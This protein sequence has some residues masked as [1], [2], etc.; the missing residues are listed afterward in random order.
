MPGATDTTIDPEVA[1]IGI[2]IVIELALQALTVA[3]AP[4]SRTTLLPCEIPNPL[5]KITTWL[6]T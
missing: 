2:V 1:P 3:A 4:F 6:P 5:P